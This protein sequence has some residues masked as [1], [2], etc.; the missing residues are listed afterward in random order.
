VFLSA[1]IILN[2]LLPEN[3]N[4]LKAKIGD[5]SKSNG[6][7]VANFRVKLYGPLNGSIFN[8]KAEC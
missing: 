4:I 1:S 8:E 2:G 3:Y 7:K 5:I 6:K